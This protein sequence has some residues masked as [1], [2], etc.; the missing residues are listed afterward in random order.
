MVKEPTGGG[1]RDGEFDGAGGRGGA[2]RFELRG[3][4]SSEALEFLMQYWQHRNMLH[5][6]IIYYL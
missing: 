4:A 1:E 2:S 5:Y 3:G 6:I